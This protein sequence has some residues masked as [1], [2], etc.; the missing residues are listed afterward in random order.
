[1]PDAVLQGSNSGDAV[2][3]PRVATFSAAEIAFALGKSPAWGRKEMARVRN[4]QHKDV[5]G[6]RTKAWA[7]ADFPPGIRE[8]LARAAQKRGCRGVA[9]FLLEHCAPW[10]PSFPLHEIAAADR[11]IAERRCALCAPVLRVHGYEAP[12]RHIAR[13]IAA[14]ASLAEE[15]C[16]RTVR[17]WIERARERDRMGE[18]WERWE[19]YLDESHAREKAA[20]KPASS[21]A[22][23]ATVDEWKDADSLWLWACQQIRQRVMD[24]QRLVRAKKEVFSVV[25]QS[26]SVADQSEGAI[27]KALNRRWQRFCT[28]VLC[29]RRHENPGRPPLVEPTEAERGALKK[30]RLKT[31]STALA[32][33][34]FATRPEC[35]PALREAITKARASNHNLPIS[36]RRAAHVTPEKEA[37]FRGRREYDLSAFTVLRA[38]TVIEADG[39]RRKLEPGE[40]WELDDM[41]LNFP[42]WFENPDGGDELAKRHGVAMGRQTLFCL[43][44]ISGKWLGAELIGRERDAY[45][46]ED[47]LRFLI[48]LFTEYGIPR[49]LRLE[50]GRWKSKAIVGQ[51]IRSLSDD[52]KEVLFGSLEELGIVVIH[53]HNAKGKGTIESGFG[54]LQRVMGTLDS[55]TYG[56]CRGEFSDDAKVIQQVR[57]GR[58]HPRAAGLLHMRDMAQVVRETMVFC[59]GRK[60]NGRIQ[61]GVPDERWYQAVSRQPLRELPSEKMFLAYPEKR[62]VQIRAGTVTC[63]RDGQQVVFSNPELFAQLGSGFSVLACFDFGNPSLGADVF[64]NEAGVKN[65]HRYKLGEYLGHAEF[66]DW[67]PQ[68]SACDGYSDENIA[69]RKR[70]NRSFRAEYVSTGLFG[71]NAAHVSEHRDGRGGVARINRGGDGS[72]AEAGATN[73]GAHI[74]KTRTQGQD[75]VEQARSSRSKVRKE[76][77]KEREAQLASEAAELD[78][79]K[80]L[81]FEAR[82][83]GDFGFESLAW[84]DEVEREYQAWLK[85]RNKG[86]LRVGGEMVDRAALIA[87]Q[88]QRDAMMRERGDF[89]PL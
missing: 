68:F 76:T 9:H 79:I 32:L 87:R 51:I 15:L 42:F 21:A 64:N 77:E 78:Y 14:R 27:K 54:Y 81:E 1:M 24:G 45:R 40:L 67:S 19:L 52:E 82:R 20:P 5:R 59:N 61:K 71:K 74:F 50:R 38:D 6:Q 13:E 60:N 31:G 37:R 18:N 85:E 22:E 53:C 73:G 30:L 46:A 8:Q 88:R 62:P 48:R 57:S 58:V 34:I 12:V 17:R 41:S 44:V 39:S 7:V 29:D 84:P 63:T 25:Q 66:M 47:I 4:V 83:R 11:A 2:C 56:K 43:D 80:K 28:G 35:G 49:Y 16:E 33:E 86:M 70:Y 10:K 89:L 72:S 65:C 55:P 26:A 36:L 75:L 3:S 23:A 69:R